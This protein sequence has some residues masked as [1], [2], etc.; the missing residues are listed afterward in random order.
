MQP[1]IIWCSIGIVLLAIELVTRKAYAFWYAMLALIVALVDYVY[2]VI[3]V[4]WQ[5]LAWVAAVVVASII[6]KVYLKYFSKPPPWFQYSKEMIG[7]EFELT[8]PIK[9]H[10]GKI[11]IEDITWYLKSHHDFEKGTKVRVYDVDGVV[12]KIEAANEKMA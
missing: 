10:Y 11:K 5:V 8:A 12:L 6:W 2:P 9:K 1:M 4:R 3:D 7:K